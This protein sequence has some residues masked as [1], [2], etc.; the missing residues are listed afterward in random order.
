MR[1]RRHARFSQGRAPRV[2]GVPG[3]RNLSGS[4][5]SFTPQK[6]ESAPALPQ[7][8]ANVRPHRPSS[9]SL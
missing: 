7:G 3:S 5:G 2:Q 8:V 6:E 9:N 1:A 4:G